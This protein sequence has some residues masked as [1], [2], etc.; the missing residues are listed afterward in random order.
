MNSDNQLHIVVP[1]SEVVYN[2]EVWRSIKDKELPVLS[3]NFL[4]F[5]YE[6]GAVTLEKEKLGF[7]SFYLNNP[8]E[9]ISGKVARLLGLVAEGLIVYDCHSDI[10]KNRRWVNYARRL[11]FESLNLDGLAYNTIS[12]NEIND[13]FYNYID[14][15]DDYL[16]VGTGFHITSLYPETRWLYDTT[17]SRDLCWIHKT[18]ATYK[19][20]PTLGTN[21]YKTRNIFAGLQIKTSCS[22]TGQYIKKILKDLK[23]GLLIFDYPIVY[24]DLGNDFS[25]IRDEI[26]C[27]N[28]N[29]AFL[30]FDFV[31]HRWSSEGVKIFF[32]ENKKLL[33]EQSFV[34]GRDI[35]PELHEALL[36]YREILTRVFTRELKIEELDSE[37]LADLR[38][39]LSLDYASQNLASPSPIMTL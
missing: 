29:L 38:V 11:E 21:K 6:I 37:I 7:S 19:Q 31:S 23:K 30:P 34:R 1:N 13:N 39:A 25:I 33:L 27:S 9:S 2:P 17:S 20:L 18:D 12:D 35:A 14:N 4:S 36:Y 15:P 22:N 32:L 16:A 26:L 24:F 5:L 28:S 3:S 10:N 8:K